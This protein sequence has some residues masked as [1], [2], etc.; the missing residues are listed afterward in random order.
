MRLTAFNF[1]GRWP[2]VF[3]F[4]LY[5]ITGIATAAPVIYALSWAVWGASIFA[6]EYISLLGSTVLAVSAFISLINRRAAARIALFGVL[7]IWSFYLPAIAGVVRMKLSDQRLTLHVVKW[8]PSPQPLTVSD[9][10]GE[11][12]PE[13][14]LSE[15]EIERL[16]EAG[17]TGR[18]DTFSCGNYGGGN[19]SSRAIV[20]IQSPVTAPVELPEP[21]ATTIIYV[22]HGTDWRPYPAG[23]P[24]LKRTIRIEP[25]PDDPKQSSIMVELSSG[26]RQGFN[27]WWPKSEP[28]KR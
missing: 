23:A 22:Q 8:T 14:R 21:D 25:W 3:P 18:V 7:A 20:V 2:L 1:R 24:I 28:G 16:K 12:R 4:A 11:T 15:A 10:V 5:L 9:P 26:A 6:T 19:K 27:I 17:V 13:A